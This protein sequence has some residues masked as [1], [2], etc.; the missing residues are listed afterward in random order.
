MADWC[1]RKGKIE[2]A[3]KSMRWLYGNVPSYDIEEEYKIMEENAL[4]ERELS[5]GTF[6]LKEYLE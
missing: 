1:A 3:K 2:R 5:T 6:N 4:R